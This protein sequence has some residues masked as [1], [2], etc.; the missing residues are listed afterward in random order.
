MAG[1]TQFGFLNVEKPAGVTSRDVVN[2]VQR[3]MKPAKVGHAGTLD[4]LATGVLVVA[5]GQA[6]RL[7]EYVQQMR[8][9]YRAT[10]LLGRSSDTEDVDGTVVELAD[11]PVPSRQEIVRV[12]G[13]MVGQLM[14]RPPAYSAIKVGGKRSYDLARAGAAVE[15]AARPV[16]VYDLA[17]KELEYP[18]LEVD[19]ECSGGT[20][21]R[22]LGRELAE[23][24]GTSAVMSELIRTAVG[25]FELADALPMDA[26]D[27][28]AIAANM[29]PPTV[30][31]GSLP[32][33]HVSVSEQQRLQ[34]GLTISLS[35]AASNH[36]E[37]QALDDAGKLVAILRCDGD[38]LRPERV[39]RNE[40]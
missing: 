20:Y 28:P 5:V 32:A 21:V 31:L 24:C 17:V 1:M 14:Q 35:I 12:A 18:R 22:T 9:R 6:T 23:R 10:F 34:N 29:L 30:A 25:A 7:I 38:L 19:V 4:P 13:E 36:A 2:R 8:K 39:F 16:T 15:L 11:A 37:Y 27:L 40:S 26:L 33:V 3:L